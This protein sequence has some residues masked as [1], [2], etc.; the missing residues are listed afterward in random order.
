M[1]CLTISMDCFQ[2]N[3]LRQ[4]LFSLC[5]SWVRSDIDLIL[6]VRFFR[7]L[8]E[9][10]SNGSYLLIGLCRYCNPTLSPPE[11]SFYFDLWVSWFLRL[12]LGW[13]GGNGTKDVQMQK[14]AI[15]TKV[16]LF[17]SNKYSWIVSSL[18]LM[19][20][21]LKKLMLVFPSFNGGEDFRKFL[22]CHSLTVFSIHLFLKAALL[23]FGNAKRNKLYFS[24]SESSQSEGHRH[25]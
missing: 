23:V 24:P 22:F 14:L 8:P 4:K 5:K 18:W 9:R 17:S 15:S 7:K 20:R 25:M 10:S 6:Q 13:K 21:V 3:P 16:Q 19:Y 11:A 2:Q 12:S 1:Q